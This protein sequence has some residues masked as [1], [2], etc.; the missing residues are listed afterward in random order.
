MEDLDK[1]LT[2]EELEKLSVTDK[3]KAVNMLKAKCAAASEWVSKSIQSFMMN[4]RKFNESVCIVAHKPLKA[5]LKTKLSMKQQ[6]LCYSRIESKNLLQKFIV[7]KL[8]FE[9]GEA[10]EM[11]K[12]LEWYKYDFLYISHRTSVPFI[13]TSEL[14][15]FMCNHF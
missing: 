5:V 9:K 1:R 12:K 10:V 11:M 8:S 7:E 6:E 14:I 2:K 3:R 13:I 4:G 15:K